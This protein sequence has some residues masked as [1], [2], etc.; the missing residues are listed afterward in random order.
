MEIVKEAYNENIN[1]IKKT[2]I[3]EKYLVASSG[4][5]LDSKVSGR[6]GHSAYFL[7]IEPQT[8]EFNVFSGIGKD[9]Y[10]QGIGKFVNLGIKKV[11]TGNIGPSAY[12]EVISSGCRIYLCRNM[13]VREA[14]KKV[15]N[16]DI[17]VLNE[18]TLKESIH[19]ARKAGGG[20]GGRGEG[21]G[22]GRGL[23]LGSRDGRGMGSGQGGGIGSGKRTGGGRGKGGK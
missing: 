16:G 10:M 20:Y 17:P 1:N 11:I 23:G 7:I 22:I 15:E 19:S 18:P 4:D 14:I 3:M 21:R 9:E 8:M 5:T 6:F 2:K 12:N 13:S